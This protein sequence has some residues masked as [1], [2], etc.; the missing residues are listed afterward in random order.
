MMACMA[1]GTNRM[2]MDVDSWQPYEPPTVVDLGSLQDITRAASG[3]G[4]NEPPANKT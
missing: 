1:S 3:T 4:T 2:T